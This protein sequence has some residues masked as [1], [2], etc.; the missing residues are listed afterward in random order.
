ML[1]VD[2]GLGLAAYAF[3]KDELRRLN[4]FKVGWSSLVQAPE[5]LISSA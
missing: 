5:P 3:G 1:F 2:F 4:E